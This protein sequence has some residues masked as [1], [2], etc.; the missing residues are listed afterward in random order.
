MSFIIKK[1]E[2][3]RVPFLCSSLIHQELAGFG[4]SDVGL[5]ASV[6]QAFANCFQ[7]GFNISRDSFFAIMEGG[8]E[9]R[10]GEV[11]TF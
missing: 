5:D 1:T 9:D 10:A 3:G 2:K 8:Q 6:F 7:L 11:S 4:E